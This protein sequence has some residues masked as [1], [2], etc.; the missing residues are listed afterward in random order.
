[1]PAAVAPPPSTHAIAG[2]WLNPH[3][4]RVNPADLVTAYAQ[5]ARRRGA[6]IEERCTVRE[7]VLRN[8]RGH[9]V[10]TDRGVFEANAVVVAAGLW[11]RP[12]LVGA[13]LPV[14]PGAC[15]H[16]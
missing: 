13:D 8:G 16:F 10:E 7:L 3:S 14:A 12:L 5:G 11:F 6:R 4:G 15:E 1:M 9:E 2:A